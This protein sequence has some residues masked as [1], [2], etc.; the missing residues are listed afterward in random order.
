MCVLCPSGVYCRHCLP[1]PALNNQTSG[2]LFPSLCLFCPS[3]SPH[4]PSISSHLLHIYWRVQLNL[5]LSWR[6]ELCSVRW[7]IVGNQEE[8]RLGMGWAQRCIVL[9]LDRGAT[10]YWTTFA[11]CFF[12]F[13]QKIRAKLAFK[14]IYLRILQRRKGEAIAGR[15]CHVWQGSS[16]VHDLR[17]D[18]QRTGGTCF[19]T[20]AERHQSAPLLNAAAIIS[21]QR[22][23]GCH[24]S[25]IT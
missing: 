15:G 21:P 6:H 8:N 9:T 16:F 2:C 25:D 18:V 7:P 19:V 13:F 14:L 20:A 23:H 5:T 10:W 24:W 3:C 12:F 1:A 17:M 22:F 4:F 11:K